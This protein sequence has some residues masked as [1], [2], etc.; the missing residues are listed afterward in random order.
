MYLAYKAQVYKQCKVTDNGRIIFQNESV[1]LLILFT[2]STAEVLK[3]VLQKQNI[4]VALKYV[5]TLKKY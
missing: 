4:I 3:G 2:E 5:S 1:Y